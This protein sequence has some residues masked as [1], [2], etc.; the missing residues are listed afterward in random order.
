MESVLAT[1]GSA[2]PFLSKVS[3]NTLRGLAR[4]TSQGCSES[5]LSRVAL[6]CPIMSKALALQKGSSRCLHAT[7]TAKAAYPINGFPS[8]KQSVVESAPATGPLS[9]G[10]NAQEQFGP[11]WNPP[12]TTVDDALPK[13]GNKTPL[14]S[15]FVTQICFAVQF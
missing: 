10:T 13:H 9:H 14:E 2:C 1:M 12:R 7:T 4:N 5:T 3:I 8:P 15:T 11:S 6:G